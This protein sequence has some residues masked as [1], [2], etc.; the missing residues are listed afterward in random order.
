MA[1]TFTTNLNLRK[2]EPGAAED[3]WGISLNA[4]LDALDAIFGLGGTAVSMGTV[5]M[6]GLT[7]ETTS[8]GTLTLN[9]TTT[10]ISNGALAGKIVFSTNDTSGAAEDIELKSTSDSFGKQTLF[11][12]TGRPDQGGLRDRLSVEH[13]GDIAFFEDTGTSKALYWDAS[14]ESLGIGTTAPAAKLDVRAANGNEIS[15]NIG[16]SDTGS[17]FKVNHAGDDLRIYNTGG[18]GKDIL[19]G[20]DAA[21][22]NQNNKVG[23]GTAS[24]AYALDLANA[25]GGNLARFKDSDS[26]HNGII[27][28]G[29]T[30]AG[31]VG[32]SASNTGE[33]IY[34]QNSINAM[35]FYANGSEKARLNSTGLNVTG[36]VEATVD[37]RGKSYR[38]Y[39]SGLSNYGKIES[40]SNGS[41]IM[42]TGVGEGARL[43]PTGLGIGTTSPSSPLSIGTT[44]SLGAISNNNI[45]SVSIDGGFSTTNATQ[46]KV[47]GF[48]GTTA[49]V[50]NIYDSSYASGETSKN[51]YTGIVSDVG[52]FNSSSYRIVQGG[53]SRLTIK[54]D[55]EFVINDGGQDRDFRVESDNNTHMLFVD[56]GNDRVGI[57]TSSPARPLTVNG[58]AGFRNS[59]TGFT[60]GDGFDIGVG[61]SDAYIVQ[62]EN[63]NIYFETNGSVSAVIDSNRNL[64]V[65][66]TSFNNDNA[67]IGL[68]ASNF[69]Y[70]TRDGNLVGSFN[71]LTSDGTILDFRKDSSIVGSIGAQGGR[72]IVGSDD[73]YLFFDSGDSPS[74][75]PHSGSAATNGVIDI[76]ESG[77]RF[78]DLYL[79]GKAQADTY[80][81]AQ[82]SSATGA[83]EAIYRATTATLAFKTGSSERMR[84]DSSGRLGLG[85][86]S[87]AVAIHAE[88]N[89]A[90]SGRTLRLA[91]DSTYYFDIEQLGAGGVAYN[92]VNASSGGHRW[93]HGGS[94][95][96]RLDFSGR[97]GIGGTP[98]VAQLDIKSSNSQK[99]IY[100]D[101]GTNALLEIKGSTSELSISS[102]ATGFAAWEDMHI[103]AHNTM[104]YQSGSEKA[105]ID[106]S[107]NLLVGTTTSTL[108][109]QSS[110]EGVS[111]QDNNIQIASGLNGTGVALYANRCAFDGEVIRLSK[112]GTKVGSINVTSSATTYNTSSDARL[113][114]VTG[115]AKGLEIINKLNPVAYNWKADNKSDEGLIAQEVEEIVP[116]SVSKGDD[117]Y[118]QMDYSK[119]V[120]P[121]IKAVQEQ[122]EQIESLK[123]EIAN[124]KGE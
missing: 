118:Y 117:G 106:A 31:W 124:L 56:G 110:E 62:R 108:H 100:C 44:G 36:I 47:I 113:K 6:D 5:T 50:A 65:G 69:F 35:R 29:D 14:A 98:S 49:G 103:K 93:E 91:F 43:T 17:F 45:I 25:S 73:T 112:S 37:F 116:N 68:G 101:D 97:L 76:G 122:Q 111:I 4:D 85:T 86:T 74:I 3:T 28:A 104:F 8:G 55:G 64:L 23:I 75:R 38:I 109:N 78:K 41:I 26:S 88:N 15:L 10:G 42:D 22:T 61:G 32:N 82:N 53:K 58:L 59:T 80:Q 71:R 60:T 63:A 7:V 46:H 107:G 27:I 24:P 30:N 2:P 66:N 21:G 77:T 40:D 79:S 1:D 81:F 33:G 39:N 34:Y 11:V 48:V 105:R 57:G 51:F 87:P 9:N 120:T 94:E 52:Y 99:Y 115:E 72:L 20:V 18:S 96:M 83:T 19:F 114:D 16:R 89:S 13:S 119:L 121:L 92:A 90:Q 12:R 102:Q 67:G 123:S 95:K 54:Q 70:A 84:L